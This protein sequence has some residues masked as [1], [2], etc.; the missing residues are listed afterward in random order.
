MR[1]N[2]A[3][4]S[5]AFEAADGL[6]LQVALAAA[7]ERHV[8]VL[9]LRVIQFF[10][11]DHVDPR[12]VPH[13][14]A[15]R[16]LAGRAR[17]PR[18]LRRGRPLSQPRL[19]ALQRPL[20]A[21]GAERLQQVIHRVGVESAHGVLVVRRHEDHRRG[22]GPRLDQL[23]H[24]EAVQFGHLDVEKHQVRRGLGDGLHRLEPVGA[25]GHD[26]DFRVR[27]QHFAQEPARQF[28]VVDN[29]RPQCVPLPGEANSPLPTAIAPMGSAAWI[30]MS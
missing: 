23:Q 27:R 18:Q 7:V 14:Q 25:L 11:R 16:P 5:R 28:F 12:A 2:R 3:G 26:L 22:V 8:V 10:E 6:L 19:G 4:S 21:L 15:L 24:L 20:E 30:T 1:T 9:R 13:R 17:F 29:Y